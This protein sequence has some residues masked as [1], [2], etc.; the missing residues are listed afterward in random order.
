MCTPYFHSLCFNLLDKNLFWCLSF[1]HGYQEM[2]HTSASDT[3][4]S[5]RQIEAGGHE[6]EG[7]KSHCAALLELPGKIK[8]LKMTISAFLEWE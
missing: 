7:E 1:V 2:L 8:L 6:G 4:A 3:S 5:F